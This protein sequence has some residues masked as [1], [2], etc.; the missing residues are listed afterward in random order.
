MHETYFVM[1]AEHSLFQFAAFFRWLFPRNDNLPRLL[2][3]L[4]L[5]LKLCEPD[6]IRQSHFVGLEIEVLLDVDQQ[7]ADSFLA[8]DFPP[9]YLGRHK[10]F[11][12]MGAPV[13]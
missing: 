10:E 9:R 13:S 8:A 12:K 1:E 7:L 2:L 11:K 4:K 6:E 5:S 3:F